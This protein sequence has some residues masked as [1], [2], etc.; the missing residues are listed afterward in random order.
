MMADLVQLPSEPWTADDTE[1]FLTRFALPTEFRWDRT[2]KRDG[3]KVAIPDQ[4]VLPDYRISKGYGFWL[5]TTPYFPGLFEEIHEILLRAPEDQEI[6][7]EW[8]AATLLERRRLRPAQQ[9][10]PI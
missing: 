3:V 5:R 4:A 7:S 10:L 8:L 9:G 1:A 6:T 2:E